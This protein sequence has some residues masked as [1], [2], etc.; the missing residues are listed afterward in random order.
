M[1]NEITDTLKTLCENRLIA[2]KPSNDESSYFLIDNFYIADFQSH[3]PTTMD[4]PI[5]EKR[6]CSEILPPTAGD[7]IYSFVIRDVENN[8]NDSSETLDL[9]DSA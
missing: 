3:I 9:I 7:K 1:I 8:G 5:I 2:N 4:T 6:A